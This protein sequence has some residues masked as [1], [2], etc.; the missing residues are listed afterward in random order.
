MDDIMK[1]PVFVLVGLIIFS[2]ILGMFFLANDSGD[3]DKTRVVKALTLRIAL[4][5]LLFALLILGYF[6]GLLQPHGI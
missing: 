3:K 1:L 4:S 5:L 6:S 2:L